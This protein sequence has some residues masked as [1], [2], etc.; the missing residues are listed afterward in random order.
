MC[1]TLRHACATNC[2]IG[3]A[4][5]CCTTTGTGHGPGALERNLT[6]TCTR[7]ARARG[8]FG[9]RSL[10]SPSSCADWGPVRLCYAVLLAVRDD[11]FAHTATFDAFCYLP[12]TEQTFA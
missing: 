12:H 5:G 2:A 3:C 9:Y 7:L 10:D 11:G 1:N 4:I 6:P 8:G